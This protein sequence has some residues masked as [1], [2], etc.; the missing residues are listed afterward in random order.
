[1]VAA[2]L[3]S[4]LDAVGTA[5]DGSDAVGCLARGGLDFEVKKVPMRHP[6]RDEVVAGFHNI[7]RTDTGDVLSVVGDKYQ[8]IQNRDFFGD[9]ADTLVAES[10]ATISRCFS[11]DGKSVHMIID[12]P[13]DE[14]ISVLGDIVSKRAII[15][16]SHDASSVA[17]ISL[18]P[19]RL[20]CLNGMVVPVGSFSFVFKIMHTITADRRITRATNILGDAGKYFE[21]F[22]R[23][24]NVMAETKVTDAHADTI[25]KS[26]APFDTDSTKSKNKLEVVTDLWRGGQRG[27]NHQAI[28]GTAWGLFNAVAEYADHKST[29]RRTRATQGNG[30][31][32]RF[33]SAVGGSGYRLKLNAYD[34][35]LSDDALG[36][37]DRIKAI[38][39]SN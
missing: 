7:V 27:G 34:R 28:R 22:G 30:S 24:M 32:S 10:N 26:I 38:I 16:N 36:I 15:K 11:A 39:A 6:N 13:R 23:A 18:M 21:Q 14:G 20:A 3:I 29:I 9:V 37:E 19:M 4:P 12:W 8:P 17:G 25:L 2:T 33:N 31:V 5:N 1:M 35:I